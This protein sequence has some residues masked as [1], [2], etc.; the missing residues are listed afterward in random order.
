VIRRGCGAHSNQF[1]ARRATAMNAR[2]TLIGREK[3]VLVVTQGATE[4]K[5]RE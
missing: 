3:I 5:R 2:Y 4:L 1:F